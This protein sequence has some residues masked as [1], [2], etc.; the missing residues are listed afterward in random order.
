[1]PVALS[2]ELMILAAA[3][4][5]MLGISIFVI[6]KVLHFLFVVSVIIV[7]GYIVVTK[8]PTVRAKYCGNSKVV[9]A[10]MPS[11]ICR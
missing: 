4:V 6:R 1:M 8:V 2:P 7:A 11:W 10:S 5:L 9:E 3:A